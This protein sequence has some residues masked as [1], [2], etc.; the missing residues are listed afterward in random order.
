V[1]HGS[2]DTVVRA[3]NVKYRKWRLG[4]GSC[5]SETPLPIFIQLGSSDHID[6]PTPYAKF[7]YNRF[8]E[9]VAAHARISPLG[10]YFFL[11]FTPFYA[12]I[13]KNLHY[14]LWGFQ[15]GITRSPLKIIVRSFYLSRI[16]GVRQSN[17]VI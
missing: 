5:N 12:T 9:G 10:V 17:S 4:E 6:H 13:F 1:Q 2:A 3:K 15:S 14:G 16:F 7:G 11:K 8:K